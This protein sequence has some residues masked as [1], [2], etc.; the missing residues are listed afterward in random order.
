MRFAGG[1]ALLLR[2]WQRF[3]QRQQPTPAEH[4]CDLPEFWAVAM[5]DEL[6]HNEPDTAWLLI[7][8]LIRQP[9][10]DDAFGC[11]AAGPLRNLIEYHGPAL[12]ERVE[13]EARANPAFRRLLRGVWESG[14]PDVWA[15][16]ERVRGAG[17]W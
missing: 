12:I 7:L 17:W 3:Y 6:A 2:D 16:V 10:S 14:T 5:L 1:H 8:E 4:N 15:R 13:D 11:L 9:L